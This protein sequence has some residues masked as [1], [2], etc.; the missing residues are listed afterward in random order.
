[1]LVSAGE[2]S[3]ARPARPPMVIAARK[4]LCIDRYA[5][6]GRPGERRAGFRLRR[7]ARARGGSRRAVWAVP[8]R[9]RCKWPNDILVAGRKLA[10]ILLK[11]SEITDHETIDF[12][13]IGAGANLASAA[14]GGRITRRPRWRNRDFPASLRSSFCKPM[15]GGSISGR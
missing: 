12:V 10:G 3:G 8:S 4:P 2:I 7:I 13:V 6:R 11:K 1:M 5:T 9:S 14:E 15:S